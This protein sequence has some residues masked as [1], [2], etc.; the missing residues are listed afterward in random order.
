MP[1]FCYLLEC[2]DGSYYCGWTTDL[3]KR[4]QAHAAGKGARYT[5]S[6]LPVSLVYFE[7]LNSRAE[8]MRREWELRQK[9][10][11]IKQNL[12]RSFNEADRKQPDKKAPGC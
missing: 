10:H 4:V 12:A 11:E 9:D 5:R 8:A 3:E 1:Y 6:R 7:E 2:R